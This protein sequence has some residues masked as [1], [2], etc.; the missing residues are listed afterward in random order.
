[1]LV[2]WPAR[3]ASLR[4]C[5]YHQSQRPP[6]G[7]RCAI[8]GVLLYNAPIPRLPL[9]AALAQCWFFYSLGSSGVELARPL[10][11]GILAQG[12]ATVAVCDLAWLT[13]KK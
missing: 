8:L 7:K 4:P 1:M 2:A 9:T 5:S 6:W 12:L 11:Q 3:D 10:W 13:A